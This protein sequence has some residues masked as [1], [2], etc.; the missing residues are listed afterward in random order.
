MKL[1]VVRLVPPGGGGG[2]VPWRIRTMSLRCHQQEAGFS[3]DVGL[4]EL[5][6]LLQEP[7][8]PKYSQ[9]FFAG[10]PSA[11]LAGSSNNEGEQRG[12]NEVD[13]GAVSQVTLPFPMSMQIRGG[14]S[15]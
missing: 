13:P 5:A 7:L 2:T 4:Q 11:A 14:L 15:K 9:R 6:R 1:Q 10:R 12:A 3:H 8:Q